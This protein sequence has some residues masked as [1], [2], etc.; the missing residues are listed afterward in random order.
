MWP[1]DV[2]WSAGDLKCANYRALPCCHVRTPKASLSVSMSH[3]LAVSV[4]IP[5]PCVA[6]V[7]VAAH[8]LAPMVAHPDV[9][10]LLL[11]WIHFRAV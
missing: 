1:A 11:L 6:A 3:V 9:P 2:R 7:H 10:P 8:G 5:Y 4:I